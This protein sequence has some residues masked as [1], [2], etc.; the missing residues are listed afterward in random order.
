MGF[1][2]T[3]TGGFPWDV[4]WWVSLGRKLVG[5]PGTL[6]GG[7]PWDVNWWVSLGR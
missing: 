2:G 7:F 4:N 1:P 6:T 5:F 3:L